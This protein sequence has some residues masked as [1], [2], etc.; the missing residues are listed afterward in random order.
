M[1]TIDL[2]ELNQNPSKAVGASYRQASGYPVLWNSVA[3]YFG[4]TAAITS[5]TFLPAG[6]GN[7]DNATVVSL[8]GVGA[9]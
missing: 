3:F 8:Y 5:L 2:R 4:S 6:G 9:L 7:F 1:E